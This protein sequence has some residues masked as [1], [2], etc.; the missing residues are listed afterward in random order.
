MRKLADI[1][2]TIVRRNIQPTFGRRLI[3]PIDRGV[4]CLALVRHAE[5]A[6]ALKVSDTG[7]ARTAVWIPKAMLTI[8][9]PSTMGIMVATMSKSF[10]EARNLHPRTIR[11]EGFTETMIAAVREAETRA[12]RKR[13]Q[14][15]GHRSP[16]SRHVNQNAFA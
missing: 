11:T 9:P 6:N 16:G 13:N 12:A 3:A 1:T 15:R 14:Y 5:T 2:E 4:T 8:D 10:A 7:D